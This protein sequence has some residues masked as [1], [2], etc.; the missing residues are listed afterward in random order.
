L[1]NNSRLLS[2]YFFLFVG[3]LFLGLQH[4]NTICGSGCEKSENKLDIG[5]RKS[6]A[7]AVGGKW[8]LSNFP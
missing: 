3:F 5:W 8:K 7:V 6:T 4:Y 1:K 2:F